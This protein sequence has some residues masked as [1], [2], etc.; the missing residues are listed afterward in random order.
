MNICFRLV[1]CFL[2]AICTVLLQGCATTNTKTTAN[3]KFMPFT[4]GIIAHYSLTAG[5][6]TNIQFYVSKDILLQRNLSSNANANIVNGRLIIRN[7]RSIDEVEV[8][9]FAPGIAQS[10]HL[11]ETSDNDNNQYD[12]IR[13]V[14]AKDAPSLVFAGVINGQ[15]PFFFLGRNQ[16][17]LVEFDNLNYDAL[18]ESL[19]AILLIDIGA[20]DQLKSQRR[21]LPGLRLKDQK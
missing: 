18:G 4:T 15:N 7:G 8:P 16:A 1:P 11:N 10:I 17:N 12:Y 21:V 19:D 6:I 9:K 13:V 20:L 2:L 3:E 14:F 5:D